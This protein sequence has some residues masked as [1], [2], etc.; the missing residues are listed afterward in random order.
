M[1]QTLFKDSELF[2]K[3]R[4][5]KATEQ[6]KSEF[7]KKMAKEVI[8]NKFV[9]NYYEEDIIHDLKLLYPFWRNNGFEMGK[10]LDGYGTRCS[11]DI[12]TEVCEWLDCLESEYSELLDKNVKDWVK[13][14]NPQPLFP[15]KTKLVVVKELNREKL[16]GDIIFVTGFRTE[17]ACYLVDKDPER[18]G[19]TVIPYE[20]IENHCKITE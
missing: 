6:Q 18:K 15:M 16:S 5:T 17:T 1:E 7:Y 20:K 9:E 14:H 12:N 13:A 19:G 8:K 4:P 3:E 11:W 10:I 2:Q